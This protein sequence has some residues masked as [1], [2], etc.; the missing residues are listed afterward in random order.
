MVGRALGRLEPYDGGNA[1][2]QI[3]RET[4][5]CAP[6]TGRRTWAKCGLRVKKRPAV[7]LVRRKPENPKA[8]D[9]IGVDLPWS[10]GFRHF[11]DR[12]GA[13][14]GNVWVEGIHAEKGPEGR[15][16]RVSGLR[17]R[18][19]WKGCARGGGAR[20]SGLPCTHARLAG[21]TGGFAIC[22]GLG[23]VL[24]SLRSSRSSL[25]GSLPTRII[26]GSG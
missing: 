4:A 11:R 10:R 1:F 8:N 17:A 20:S 18:G 7:E 15:L 26:F 25:A 14:R 16:G 24:V 21:W 22:T 13:G 5:G 6:A 19:A 9:V 12:V 3:D 2:E 23:T